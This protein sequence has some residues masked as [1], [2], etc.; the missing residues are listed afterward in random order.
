MIFF[1]QGLLCNLTHE[2][3]NI[4]TATLSYKNSWNG[5]LNQKCLNIGTDVIKAIIF[6]ATK[7]NF[8]S[9]SLKRAIHKPRFHACQS[10]TSV[11]KRVKRVFDMGCVSSW[12]LIYDPVQCRFFY[13]NERALAARAWD[14]FRRWRTLSLVAAVISCVFSSVFKMSGWSNKEVIVFGILPDQNAYLEPQRR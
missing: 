6:S 9:K 13:T 4:I 12:T 2:K 3:N 11:H 1:I 10:T 7:Y 8:K 14:A 5:N